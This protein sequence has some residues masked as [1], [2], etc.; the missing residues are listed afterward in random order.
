VF[1]RFLWAKVKEVKEMQGREEHG[2]ETA[3]E[4]TLIMLAGGIQAA[5]LHVQACKKD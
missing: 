2:V 5:L 4:E 1:R 3:H